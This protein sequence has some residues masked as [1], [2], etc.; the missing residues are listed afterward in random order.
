[1]KH[2]C[3]ETCVCETSEAPQKMLEVA[4]A[5]LAARES[6][7]I[8]ESGADIAWQLLCVREKLA[9]EKQA[10]HQTCRLIIE[11]LV[12]LG[13]DLPALVAAPYDATAVNELCKSLPAKV[14][15]VVKQHDEAVAERDGLRESRARW[16]Q[17]CADSAN[18]YA[19]Q[20]D[21]S[22]RQVE[23]VQAE[24]ER[25]G[26]KL[27]V[28]EKAPAVVRSYQNIRRVYDEAVEAQPQPANYDEVARSFEA[29]DKALLGLVLDE[30]PVVIAPSTQI[31]KKCPRCDSPDP[32]R[33]PAVQFEDEVQI[34]PHPFHAS[35]T[36]LPPAAAPVCRMCKDTHALTNEETGITRMCTF[37]PVPCQLCRING[38]GPYCTT[39]PCECSCHAKASKNLDAETVKS[40]SEPDKSDGWRSLAMW[41]PLLREA[42]KE[43]IS[44]S[45]VSGEEVA[46][47]V[48]PVGATW[49][50]VERKAAALLGKKDCDSGVRRR[51]F[52]AICRAVLGA[53]SINRP[54]IEGA[55]NGAY[56]QALLPPAGQADA[57]ADDRQHVPIPIREIGRLVELAAQRDEFRMADEAKLA[58]VETWL[59]GLPQE[60]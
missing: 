54:D 45:S 47:I 44:P 28:A 14:R 23:R 9:I 52:N 60:T 49:A 42:H 51:S 41:W 11:A 18:K 53:P 55:Y 39:T 56:D 30:P 25:L 43:W 22:L 46:A 37:C 16:Q 20:R 4:A 40:P 33:H 59:A 15:A 38:N 27:A 8:I 24:V 58:A 2:S 3:R 35:P 1:M 7:A 34:C 19:D 26:S 12:E 57:I 48:R 32:E 6:S 36:A 21:E 29:A 13:L 17:H 5:A 50:D 31:G 10:G